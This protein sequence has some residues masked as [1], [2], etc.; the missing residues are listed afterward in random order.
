METPTVDMFRR[1]AK[2][3]YEK[4][5]LSNCL[6]AVDGKHIRVKCPPNSGSM[7]YNYKN[8]FSI[9]L[10][11]VADANY[12]FTIIDVGGYGKQSYGGTFQSSSFFHMLECGNLHIPTDDVWLSTDTEVPFVFVGDKAYPLL[13]NLMKPYGR[14]EI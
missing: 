8:Y 10:H 5:N 14:R 12:R 11:A 7:Y 2:G 4:W 3:F 1:I 9:V 6:G 13:K